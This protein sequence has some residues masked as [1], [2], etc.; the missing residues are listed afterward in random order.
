MAGGFVLCGDCG[1]PDADPDTLLC[2][3]CLIELPP[4]FRS[5]AE[6]FAI[7]A[8]LLRQHLVEAPMG[9]IRWTEQQ[10]HE[11]LRKTQ[12]PAP[13]E[14]SGKPGKPP[15]VNPRSLTYE[16][17]LTPMRNAL[18]RM[19]FRAKR[20]LLGQLG[21][22]FSRQTPLASG[23]PFPRAKI[24]I[25][26]CS[27]Q[28][29]DPDAMHGFVKPILDAMQVSSKRH[30]YGASIIENDTSDCIELHTRWQKAP[31]K[32]GKVIVIVTPRG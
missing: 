26:R 28:E 24:E 1:R 21:E 32:Q 9:G 14:K 22:L 15:K 4:Y 8:A 10:L 29:P 13:K 16:L 6:H 27:S 7:F 11:H 20:R 3:Y 25:V 18:D 2:V 17:P 12:A 23:I 5:K 19:H 30:P 31:A